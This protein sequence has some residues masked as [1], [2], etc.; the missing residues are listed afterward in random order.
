MSATQHAETY[1]CQ[2]CGDE[3]TAEAAV[4][5][6]YC[7]AGCFYRHR[8]ANTLRKIANDHRFCGTCFRRV[9]ETSRPSDDVLLDAGVSSGVREAFIGFE[10][11]TE[12]A[13]QAVDEFK[14]NTDRNTALRVE[15]LRLSCQCGTV[16]LSDEHE[17]LR[18]LDVRESVVALWQAL[19]QLERDG[20]LQQRPI[21]DD[22]FAAFRE[23]GPDWPYAVGRSLFAA[24]E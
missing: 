9:K 8:G 14:S 11:S 23:R 21:K 10:E 4:K 20:V 24:P 12:H 5:G 18:E 22:Y 3:H 1:R 13:V 6:S 2:Q 15:G 19:V 16:D 7:S 17:V